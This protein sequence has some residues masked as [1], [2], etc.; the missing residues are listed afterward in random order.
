M[1]WGEDYLPDPLDGDRVG[2]LGGGAGE[3]EV[4][5]R[6]MEKKERKVKMRGE[7]R[8]ESLGLRET[9]QALKE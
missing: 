1:G 5:L 9:M 4:G 7:T 2:R 3:G 8:W 6:E